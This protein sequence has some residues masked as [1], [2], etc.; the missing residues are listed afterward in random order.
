MVCHTIDRDGFVSERRLIID[1]EQRTKTATTIVSG[2]IER[3]GA[4][5]A[6]LL[7]VADGTH[8]FRKGRPRTAG[9][10]HHTKESRHQAEYSIRAR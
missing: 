5:D 10:R 1:C 2:S 6:Y 7:L 8:Q 4:A 9:T 3:E